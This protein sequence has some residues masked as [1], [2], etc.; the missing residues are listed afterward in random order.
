MS[1]SATKV[2]SFVGPDH[3][4]NAR[5]A[6]E[7]MGISSAVLTQLPP[8]VTLAN[9]LPLRPRRTFRIP[10]GDSREA[11]PEA[12]VTVPPF[13]RVAKLSGGDNVLGFS[14][15]GEWIMPAAVVSFG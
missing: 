1:K 8:P 7:T 11:M 9:P 15:S 10:L 12:T 2:D 6:A 4:A 13:L 3:A 14:V 5:K